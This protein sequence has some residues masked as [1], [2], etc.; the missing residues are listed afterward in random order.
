MPFEE[1]LPEWNAPG[2]E[3]PASKKNTGWTPGEK[4]PAEYWNWQM[5]RTYMVLKELREKVAEAQDLINHISSTSGVH[6]ATSAATPNTLVQRDPAGR[7]KAAAPVAADDVARKADVDAITTEKINTTAYR[8]ATEDGSTYPIGVTSFAVSNGLSDGWP[9]DLGVVSTTKL[10]HIRCLQIFMASSAT[11]A[12]NGR[13][14]VR[15]WRSD[16]GWSD[17]R[18]QWD[19]QEMG[20]GSGL[21]ADL[22]DGLHASNF[23]TKNELPYETG[24]WTPELRFGNETTGIT[25]TD[26][27]GRYTRIGNVV[28][29]ELD[30]VL[31]SKGTA[32]GDAS[33]AG[34]PFTSSGSRPYFYTV[35][36]Y[37]NITLPS[38]ATG[39][40]F[41]ISNNS[42]IIFLRQIGNGIPVTQAFN[43][44]HFTNNSYLRAQGKYTI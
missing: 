18:R 41:F 22:L 6:G 8:P 31:S 23:W 3:P 9:T 30:I 38:N 1:K 11:G 25:Y 19:S 14:Y 39:M 2:I 33:I 36:G 10:S 24:G 15:S 42:S 34:L 13:V 12:Q 27:F 37:A 40:V 4:P 17:W 44:S 21:D 29:W 5:H 28:F 32:S 20:A 16:S 26:R 35:G 7:F 43:D